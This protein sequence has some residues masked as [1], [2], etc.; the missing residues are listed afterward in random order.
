MAR[1]QMG[2]SNER[3][4]KRNARASDKRRNAN[5]QE[6]ETRVV[7]VESTTEEQIASLAYEFWLLRGC[8]IGTPDEDWFRAEEA[9]RQANKLRLRVS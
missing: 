3:V 9:L 4:Q 8:P 5:A 7:P 1:N 6:N 2:A